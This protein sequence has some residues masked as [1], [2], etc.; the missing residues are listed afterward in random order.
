[1]AKKIKKADEPKY[2]QYITQKQYDER[3]KNSP[4]LRNV[5]IP[6]LDS[7]KK[8]EFSIGD[9]ICRYYTDVFGAKVYYQGEAIGSKQ[10]YRVVCIDEY[11]L[12]FAKAIRP[13]GLLHGRTICISVPGKYT[14]EL[15]EQYQVHVLMG[16]NF[17][18]EGQ[19]KVNGDRV[20]EIDE[21]NKSVEIDWGKYT[22][23]NSMSK[24]REY[25]SKI[26]VGTIMYFRRASERF[27]NS[28]IYEGF[29]SGAYQFQFIRKSPSYH[30]KDRSVR[31]VAHMILEKN[32]LVFYESKPRGIDE[33]N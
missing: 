29:I 22:S 10:L 16:E 12:L 32:Y 33:T 25:F 17:D 27:I 23:P 9:V 26:P 28:V 15:D 11:G 4:N 14:Y 2:N 31:L 30:T 3:Y 21:Y 1:M 24:V 5:F 20:K 6:L 18:A 13:T 7:I 19:A 8:N